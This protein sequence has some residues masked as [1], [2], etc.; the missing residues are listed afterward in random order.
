M[1]SPLSYRPRRSDHP[2]P[3]ISERW[4]EPSRMRARL[5]ATD[6]GEVLAEAARMLA[7]H[8][9][10]AADNLARTLLARSEGHIVL[11]DGVSLPHAPIEGLKAPLAALVTTA[12]PIAID[13]EEADVFFVLLAPE[14]DPQAHLRALAHVGRLCHDPKLLDRLRAA[15]ATAEV[16]DALHDAARSAGDPEPPATRGDRLLAII[17]LSGAT[18]ATRLAKLVEDGFR[19]P[20]E[21]TPKDAIYATFRRVV[22]A[23]EGNRFLV[24]IEPRDADVLET[25]IA[26]QARLLGRSATARLHLLRPERLFEPNGAA[27]E[28]QSSIA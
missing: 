7:P 1:S 23:E 27:P 4:I 16:V 5:E 24:S 11:G 21:L 8:A 6:I 14:S 17:E 22:R 3:M 18:T 12:S 10:V 13:D 25:L 28:A 26:E 15:T 19:R 9:G 20:L 2:E